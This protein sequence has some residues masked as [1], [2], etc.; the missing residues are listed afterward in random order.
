MTVT[1]RELEGAPDLLRATGGP[2]TTASGAAGFAGLCSVVDN[3]N[4]PDFAMTTESRVLIVISE[5]QLDD[6]AA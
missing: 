5:A 6:D 3:M 1:E 2:A 4:E